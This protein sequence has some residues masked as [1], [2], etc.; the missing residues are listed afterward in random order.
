MNSIVTFIDFKQFVDTWKVNRYDSIICIA[1]FVITLA[2]APRLYIPILSGV[3]L[4]LIFYFYRTIKNGG[5]VKTKIENS[6]PDVNSVNYD[7]ISIIRLDR[8]LYFMNCAKFE[9]KVLRIIISNP[10]LN[11]IIFD[12]SNID[13]IDS[14]ATHAMEIIV[15]RMVDSGINLYFTNLKNNV[16][17]TF[18]KTG[19]YQSIGSDY[20]F[21]SNQKA[22]EQIHNP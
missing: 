1:T 3:I 19:L 8:H 15:N 7:H 14:S 21:N 17:K 4:S 9:D 18:L 20:F 16:F 2:F 5:N 22:I 11:S 13:Y 6:D 12:M 10:E